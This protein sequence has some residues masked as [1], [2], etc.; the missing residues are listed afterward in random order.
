MDAYLKTLNRIYNLRG[1]I[2]DLRLERMERALALF[3]HPEKRFPSFHIAGT[4]GKGST[5][6]MLHRILCSA[7][8]RTALYTSPHLVSFTERVRIDD[9]E[10]T[11]DEVVGLAEEIWRRTEAANILL[12][13]FEIVTV[14]AFIH[15]ARRQVDLAVIEVGLGGRFDAT[16]LVRSI[17]S[18]ITTISKDHEAFLGSDIASIAREKAGII[19]K[20]VPVVCGALPHE[21]LEV[22][23]EIAHTNQAPCYR[24]GRNFT[25]KL[26]TDGAFDY[27]SAKWNLQD[28]SVA[29]HGAHQIRNAGVATAALE[30]VNDRFPTS[31]VAIRYGLQNVSWPG[32]MEVILTDPT[33]IIDGA[34]NKEG[35]DVLSDE[36][37]KLRGG[38]RIR[39]LI[40]VMEDKD[41]RLMLDTLAGVADEIVLTRVTELER[42][43]DPL[44]LQQQVAGKL[45]SQVISDPR[46]AVETLV[47]SAAPNEL[48]V[49]TGSLYLLGE[50]R[51]LLATMAQARRSD[52]SNLH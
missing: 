12:T 31:E 47:Q 39:M 13:F 15:F 40:A 45:Q 14:M 33:V 36:L 49:I 3:D 10:I 41:W 32:R 19:K 4:N 43:A 44:Q 35:I 24:L 5:A 52:Q 26:K 34:H 25:L 17:V 48:I 50:V 6:A 30:V 29:L 7:G 11:P 37:R 22:I 42:S 46:L 20:G 38:R 9:E 18:V 1:G 2:I 21:P 8:Y 27:K 16:N 28:L 51:P 23:E